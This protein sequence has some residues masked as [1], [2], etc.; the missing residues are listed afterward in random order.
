M[1]DKQL[2]RENLL[3][4]D[5][6]LN[7][8][9]RRF[10]SI[11]SVD[12]FLDSDYGLDMLDSIAMMLVAVGESFKKI[13]KETKGMLLGNYPD[14]NWTGVKG[15]RDV[16]SHQYFNIDAEVIFRLCRKDLPELHHVVN[17]MLQNI[18][19]F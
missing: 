11:S 5:E 17:D 10:S 9:G 7:R 12:D 3:Q 18:E 4:I 16:L 15:I 19:K 14:I 6:A 2:L 13:D 1:H 8:I